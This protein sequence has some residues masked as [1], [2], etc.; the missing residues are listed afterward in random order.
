MDYK[1]YQNGATTDH[2]W[3]KAKGQLI[4]LLL[5][6]INKKDLTILNAGAG[7]GEDLE[8]IR[9][10]GRIHAIDIEEKALELI[11]QELVHEKKICNI[12]EL[13]YENNFF[14]LAVA[15]DVLE[16]IEQDTQAT[17]EI[18]RALKPGGFFVFTVPA[19]QPLFSSRDQALGHHRRYNKKDIKK[20]LAG[21]S[22]HELNY[23]S[24]SLFLPTLLIKLFKKQ[25]NNQKIN[26]LSP[27]KLI[28]N[29]FYTFLKAEN[30]L[31]KHHFALPPGTTLYGICQKPTS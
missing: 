28:N 14:D 26:Y 3:F 6:K 8:T 9:K 13:P 15:F 5:Q 19:F 1:D 21:F 16:H 31:A 30:F 4:N 29:I 17:Q 27:P 20:L 12:C 2:F 10:F 18:Y 24:S 25:K 23:W 7:I 11:P 22:F